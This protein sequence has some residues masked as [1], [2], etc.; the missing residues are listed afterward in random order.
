MYAL[1]GDF[2]GNLYVDPFLKEFVYART[3]VF[4]G[5]GEL[6]PKTEVIVVRNKGSVTNVYGLAVNIWD[7]EVVSVW[8]YG[9]PFPSI[10]ENE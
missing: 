3:K 6:L 2:D 5:I 9:V 1:L 4:H 7:G 10:V 8:N